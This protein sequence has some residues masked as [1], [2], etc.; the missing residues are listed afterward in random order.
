MKGC[1][2]EV[3]SP[4]NLEIVESRGS[5]MLMHKRCGGVYD[6]AFILRENRVNRAGPYKSDVEYRNA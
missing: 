6:P 3:I 2:C 4:E 1:S 5:K